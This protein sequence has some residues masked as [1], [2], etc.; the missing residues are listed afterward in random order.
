[1]RQTQKGRCG[2]G[3]GDEPKFHPHVAKHDFEA[4]LLP[5]WPTIQELAG[6]NRSAPAGK[7]ESVN[8]NKPP[9]YWI[10][11]LFK[12]GTCPGG[13]NKV[14]DAHRILRKNDLSVAIVRCPKLKAFVETILEA[15][16]GA[17]VQ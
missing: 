14:T 4:W 8:H 12:A 11:E 9:S 10:K 17:P 3:V 15:C 16:G 5:Y 2:S 1:M 6:H 13:Y 7:P